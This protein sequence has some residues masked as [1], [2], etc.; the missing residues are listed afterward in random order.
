MRSS[1]Q[2]SLAL[3]LIPLLYPI[4]SPF[5]LWLTGIHLH[6]LFVTLVRPLV[7]SC[8]INAY[9]HPRQ[10]R[11]FL[12]P[13]PRSLWTL[14]VSASVLASVALRN[15]IFHFSAGNFA[16]L[17][18]LISPSYPESASIDGPWQDTFSPVS[19]FFLPLPSFQ[20]FY[21]IGRYSL[22][23]ALIGMWVT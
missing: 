7:L 19:S 8:W 13:H 6:R 14:P 2:K 18:N 23:A 17:L 12:Q 16:S 11:V 20:T 1:I 5:D 10:R 21:F 3:V 4:L 22:L 9:T 15:P